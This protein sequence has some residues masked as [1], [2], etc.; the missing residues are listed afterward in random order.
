MLRKDLQ[1]K[2][3]SD[4]VSA[5]IIRAGFLAYDYLNSMN[6][7]PDGTA[8]SWEISDG[9]FGSPMTGWS[10]SREKM[11]VALRIFEKHGVFKQRETDFKYWIEE[12][13]G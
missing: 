2:L 12:M 4:K 8:Y 9:V 3:E 11:Q 13:L 10:T 1:G 6:K 5:D 7:C